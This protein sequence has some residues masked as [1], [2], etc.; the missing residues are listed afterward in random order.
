MASMITSTD[1]GLEIETRRLTSVIRV[2]RHLGQ[3]LRHVT[4][5]CVTC[6]CIAGN[7]LP[8]KRGVII[9]QPSFTRQRKDKEQTKSRRGF[10]GAGNPVL[11]FVYSLSLLCL[12]KDD[13]RTV[14]WAVFGL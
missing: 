6:L 3:E 1:G 5:A 13:W 7:D 2:I 14:T 11:P 8:N 4:A 10:P 9:G 12:I